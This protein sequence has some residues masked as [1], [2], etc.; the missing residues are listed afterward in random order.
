MTI[1]NIEN[2]KKSYGDFEA[3]KDVSFLIQEN[4]CLALLGTNGAGKTTTLKMIYSATS[5]TE[6]N[7][8]IA[9]FNVKENPSK[10]KS[11]IGIVSQEDLLDL[12]LTVLENMI[13]HAICYNIS[14]KVATKKAMEL[15]E[16]VGLLNYIDKNINELS[17]GMRR[18]VVLARA[19]INE[20]KLIILD[21]PTTG[22][23]IQSRH[24]IWN[25]L[26]ELKKNGV[27]ILL[28]SHYM[29]EVE[30]LA[31]RVII[32]H[33]GV[34]LAEGK[35]SELPKMNNFTTLEETFLH[36]TGHKEGDESI[37]QAIS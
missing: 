37:V 30:K 14:K 26:L 36:L 18:R 28:T 31:D 29:D 11:I 16:F 35:P 2:L 20:P 4:E 25:K 17:G 22:L 34:I 3:V 33:Q 12:S 13:A 27:S 15:L 24:I 10:T 23:D 9:G 5:I 19:L 6:G 1:L 8:E 32:I 21:E 7:I